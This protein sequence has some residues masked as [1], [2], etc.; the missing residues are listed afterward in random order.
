[1]VYSLG[2]LISSIGAGIKDEKFTKIL[3]NP[4]F[5]TIA[6]SVFVIIMLTVITYKSEFDGKWKML[7]VFAIVT[8]A[9]VAG[10]L[11]LNRYMSKKTYGGFSG[12]TQLPNPSFFVPVARHEPAPRN[13]EVVSAFD[14]LFNE[15]S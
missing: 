9:G 13:H 10:I 3:G 7:S 5:P 15:L 4:I 12:G 8:M 11:F 1:M 6:V 14:D 2:G